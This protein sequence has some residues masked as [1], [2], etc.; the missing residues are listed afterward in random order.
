[1]K[2]AYRLFCL[3]CLPTYL[4]FLFIIICFDLLYEYLYVI[5]WIWIYMNI[6]WIFIKYDLLCLFC[7]PTFLFWMF[8]QN[9]KVQRYHIPRGKRVSFGEPYRGNSKRQKCKVNKI[10]K[11]VNV[12]PIIIIM[13]HETSYAYATF[14]NLSFSSNVYNFRLLEILLWSLCFQLKI[15]KVRVTDNSRYNCTLVDCT[16]K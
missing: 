9:Y 10:E 7:L 6:I 13:F 11:Y 3:L 8:R 1:M 5:I 12:F 2:S 4:F 15:K 14:W 16:A